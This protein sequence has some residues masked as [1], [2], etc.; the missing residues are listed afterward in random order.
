MGLRL[1]LA[2]ERGGLIAWVA[3]ALFIPSLAL[4]LVKRV[5]ELLVGGPGL[6]AL[7]MSEGRS[8]A[9]LLPPRTSK[10]DPS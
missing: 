6:I 1:L 2:G 3:G 8:L 10:N 4:A 9:R 5:R 7:A